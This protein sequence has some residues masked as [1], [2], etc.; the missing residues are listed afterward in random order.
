MC[1]NAK[2]DKSA[3]AHR[4]LSLPASSAVQPNAAC[5]RWWNLL[6]VW[7]VTYNRRI[8]LGEGKEVN[9]MEQ[10]N[11]F[12]AVSL[13]AAI[14]VAVGLTSASFAN[15]L[16]ELQPKD[17]RGLVSAMAAVLGLDEEGVDDYLQG[18]RS[19]IRYGEAVLRSE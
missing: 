17:G 12:L 8:W 1:K 14:S 4:G 10:P 6:A 11:D 15:V 7:F 9:I 5:G 19:E 13:L 18:R 3:P 16:T 2:A